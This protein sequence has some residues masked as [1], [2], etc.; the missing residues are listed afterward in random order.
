LHLLDRFSAKKSVSHDLDSQEI[1][2]HQCL[3]EFHALL[4]EEKKLSRK[5]TSSGFIDDRKNVAIKKIVGDVESAL[6]LHLDRSMK[7]SNVEKG[8][9]PTDSLLLAMADAN[10]Q[11]DLLLDREQGILLLQQD[12]G[13]LHSIFT[14]FAH[15]VETQGMLLD[16][17]EANIESAHRSTEAGEIEIREVYRRSKKKSILW[18]I[19]FL[20]VVVALICI[21]IA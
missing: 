8:S 15:N 20:L 2:L 5:D 16:N 3:S 18:V 4:E 1:D 6:S 13:K 14:E 12:I 7:S 10:Q 21:I 17:I 11:N 9:D 19:F